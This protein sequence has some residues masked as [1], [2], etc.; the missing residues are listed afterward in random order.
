MSSQTP[1]ACVSTNFTI[2]AVIGKLEIYLIPTFQT[3]IKLYVNNIQQQ[4]IRLLKRQL[5]RVMQYL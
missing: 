3:N 4:V 2:I 5:Y 1:Q